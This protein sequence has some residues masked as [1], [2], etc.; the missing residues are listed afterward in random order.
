M[1]EDSIEGIFDTLKTCAKISKSAGGIGLSIH[2]VRVETRASL[3]FSDFLEYEHPFEI[4]ACQGIQK[5]S[6]DLYM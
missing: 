4:L 3:P 6:R 1:K 5:D 2:D